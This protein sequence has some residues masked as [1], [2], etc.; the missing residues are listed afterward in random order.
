MKK[1]WAKTET[2]EERFLKYISV[3]ESTGCWNWTGNIDFYG[4]GRVGYKMKTYRA[5]RAAFI[6]FKATDPG[7][8]FVC[9]KCDNPKCAN[10]DH[11]FLGTQRQNMADCRAKKRQ[12]WG[13][14]N[15]MAK[16]KNSEIENIKR[17]VKSGWLHREVAEK[18]NV[19]RSCIGAIVTGIRRS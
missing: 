8:K 7:R 14:R 16:I 4:Y 5:S 3:D 12:N 10:P 15:G 19:S 1:S 6:I 13:E 11:L 2:F 17:L 18:Y 9:H